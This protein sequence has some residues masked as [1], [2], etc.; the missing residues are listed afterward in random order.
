MSI[1]ELNAALRTEESSG[2]RAALERNRQRLEHIN[3]FRELSGD[4]LFRQ[5]RQELQAEVD[6]LKEALCSTDASQIQLVQGKIAGLRFAIQFFENR[7]EEA[8]QL[9]DDASD[10]KKELDILERDTTYSTSEGEEPPT[11]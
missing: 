7:A 5:Y 11:Y 3:S 10:L 2:L 1:H 9:T 4:E 6:S 8:G